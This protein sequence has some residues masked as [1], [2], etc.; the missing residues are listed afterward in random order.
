M[1]DK[2]EYYPAPLKYQ[3]ERK[4]DKPHGKGKLLIC[5][6]YKEHLIYEG[7]FK[8]GEFYGT[9]KEYY[10]SSGKLKYEGM[11]EYGNILSTGK[12][13][14]YF[15]DGS[16]EEKLIYNK[17]ITISNLFL[18]DGRVFRRERVDGKIVSEIEITQRPVKL[19]E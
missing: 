14:L 2:K 1:S 10:P 16:K 18:A 19:D 15:L 7:E 12:G 9:G 8:D 3:G 4:D 11:W 13:T 17:H 6:E 5:D